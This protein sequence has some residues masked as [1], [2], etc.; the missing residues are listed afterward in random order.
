M[1]GFSFAWAPRNLPLGRDAAWHFLPWVVALMAYLAALGAIGLIVAQATVRATDASFAETMTLQ[2]P[3]DTSNARLETVLAVLR[4]TKGIAD[5]HLLAPAE[6]ARLLEPW[7]GP[8]VP[9]EQ[10]PIPRLIDV[11]I[12]PA[13]P[14]DLAAL[15]HQLASVVPDARLDDHRASLGRARSAAGRIEIVLSAVI[16]VALV[17]IAMSAV[18]AVRT[19]LSI[20]RASIEV[21]H[22]LGAPDIDV[23]RQIAMRYLQLGLSGG[24]I[25]AAAATLTVVAVGNPGA[26]LLVP[27]NAASAATGLAD[28]R[29]W[30]VLTGV[31]L[32]AGLIAMASA[33]VTV[34]RWLARMP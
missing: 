18:Y 15:R 13:A 9:L 1:I 30:A 24:A 12:D 5:A 3:A 14:P 11:R 28:W 16:V 26:F 27:T 19:G 21:V 33:A 29:F 4:Q 34:L 7:L 2:V 17:L 20:Q 31:A 25:G 8:K 6:T 22:L 10:L 23:A 32:T